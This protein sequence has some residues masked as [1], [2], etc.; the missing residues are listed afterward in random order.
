PDLYDALT[1]QTAESRP[2]ARVR[3]ITSDYLDITDPKALRL[4]VLLQAQGARVRV[5][6]A[7]NRSFHLKAYL[8]THFPDPS[9]L[10][11]TVFI[12]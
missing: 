10:N 11:G 1:R 12:G 8:F 4:L 6:E 3:I 9:A 7:G 5:F 2:P